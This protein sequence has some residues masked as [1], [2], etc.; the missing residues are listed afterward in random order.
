MV[1]ARSAQV[2]FIVAAKGPRGG[3]HVSRSQVSVANWRDYQVTNQGIGV[4]Q[5]LLDAASI[6]A[7]GDVQF[8]RDFLLGQDE[9]PIPADWLAQDL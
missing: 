2:T 4:S 1:T 7:V 3:L 5:C 6:G 8:C 9:Y